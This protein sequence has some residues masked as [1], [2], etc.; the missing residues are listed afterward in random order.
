[1]SKSTPTPEST[2]VLTIAEG[3][4]K[5]EV[6]PEALRD[7]G[8]RIADSDEE[9]LVRVCFVVNETIHLTGD[10]AALC[11]RMMA[12]QKHYSNQMSTAKPPEGLAKSLTEWGAGIVAPVIE[13]VQSLQPDVSDVEEEIKDRMDSGDYNTVELDPETQELKDRVRATG[14]RDSEVY[15]AGIAAEHTDDTAAA[16]L[17]GFFG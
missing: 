1:M 10:A 3:V 13:A 6:T 12:V 5:V 14:K 17:K 16:E 9:D 15:Q 11:G 2:T 4:R 7:F 8:R